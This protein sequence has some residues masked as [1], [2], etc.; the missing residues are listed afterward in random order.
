MTK[1][2]QQR[3]KKVNRRLK[4]MKLAGDEQHAQV[5]AELHLLYKFTSHVCYLLTGDGY[6]PDF[7]AANFGSDFKLK[8][9][10][11]Q[12]LTSKFMELRQ[13]AEK[14]LSSVQSLQVPPAKSARSKVPHSQGNGK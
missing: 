12:V 13:L 8:M 4:E 10:P 5:M 11:Y 6:K 3:L 2:D 9:Y 1:L 7:K 14:T